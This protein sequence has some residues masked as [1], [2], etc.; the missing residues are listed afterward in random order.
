MDKDRTDIPQ[1][2]P[3]DLASVTR[4]DPE[5]FSPREVS[6][7]CARFEL[8]QI[9]SLREFNRGSPQSPKLIVEAARG[10]FLLKRRSSRTS[11]PF[12]VAFVH[13]V[14][15][16]LNA[17]GFPTPRIIGTRD[18]NNSMLQRNGLVYE[19]FQFIEGEPYTGRDGEV[20]EAART[21]ARL[22]RLTAEHRPAWVMPQ[23]S[24]RVGIDLALATT[25]IESRHPGARGAL[26]GIVPAV[27]QARRY[28]DRIALD[29]RDVRI[30]HG[31]WHPGNLI[32][33]EQRVAA[34]LDFDSA[35]YAPPIIELANGLLQFSMTRFGPDP[36]RWPYEPDEANLRTFWRSY[37]AEAGDWVDPSQ[38]AEAMP[39]LMVELLVAEAA[40]PILET[41]R[42]GRL[43]AETCLTMIERKTAWL[44]QNAGSLR[45]L[46][47]VE[48]RHVR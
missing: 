31:D 45:D 26:H 10:R 40:R 6:E 2:E 24:G 11:D 33:R 3:L 17:R 42:F 15:L 43:D 28:L 12:R 22:H 29:R 7:V 48:S 30:V 16:F 13:G 8:G 36:A 4:I 23:P 9:T 25:M 5:R 1:H 37:L 32:F 19:L 44:C 41:G 39:W 47:L 20:A 35:R 27:E 14:Q 21:L 18:D 34:V 38:D 46:L